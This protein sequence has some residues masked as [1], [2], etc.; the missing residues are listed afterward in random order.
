M[1]TATLG[2][3]S[4]K[5]MFALHEVDAADKSIVVCPNVSRAAL[6]ALNSG[7]PCAARSA[8][9]PVWVAASICAFLAS[10]KALL[11]PLRRCSTC[12]FLR[13][14]DAR[15][16]RLEAI[17]GHRCCTGCS[18]HSARSEGVRTG[19]S[20]GISSAAR[21]RYAQARAGCWSW[22]RM[23][24]TITK[25]SPGENRLCSSMMSIAV[26]TL[27]RSRLTP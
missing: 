26:N 10:S 17:R 25:L 23:K 9:K 24:R 14:R 8:W 19:S 3:D 6:T 27:E 16:N 4:A 12:P 15:P 5:S 11:R 18:V 2:I 21:S 7:L 20:D 22:V 1:A 13:S